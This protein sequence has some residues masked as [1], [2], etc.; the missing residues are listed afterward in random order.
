MGLL[1]CCREVVV[2]PDL[3]DQDYQQ[4]EGVSGEQVRRDDA[5]S[6]EEGRLATVLA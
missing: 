6:E 3:C 2:R 1:L 5:V 4:P